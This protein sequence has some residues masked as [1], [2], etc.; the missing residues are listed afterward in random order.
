MAV[1]L[2][3]AISQAGPGGGLSDLRWLSPVTLVGTLAALALIGMYLYFLFDL[4]SHVGSIQDDTAWARY[5]EI[6]AALQALAFAA[7]GALLGTTVQKQVTN[8]ES[9]RADENADA[10][11][12]NAGKLATIQSLGAG[13]IRGIEAANARE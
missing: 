11:D 2:L 13:G 5:L 12:A 1:L 10:A 6:N 8:A 9:D 4:W 3:V 7:A